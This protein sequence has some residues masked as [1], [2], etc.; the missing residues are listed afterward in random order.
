MGRPKIVICIGSSCFSRGNAKNVEITEN[1]LET[2]GLKDDIDVELSGA[3][4]RNRCAEGPIVEV[5][6]KI[7]TEVDSGLMLDILK[8]TFQK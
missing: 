1:F 2:N 8:Q 3:L 4:C 7:Y 5:N 6:G